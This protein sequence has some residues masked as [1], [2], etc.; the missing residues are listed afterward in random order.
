[1]RIVGDGPDY[2]RLRRLAGPNVE[3]LGAR[4]NEEIRK[5]YRGA[6]AFLLP[7]EED[8]GIAP[9]EALA[10]G[11]PVV[12]LDR[13]GGTREIMELT[14]QRERLVD[15]LIWRADWLRGAGPAREP[16]LSAFSVKRAT[17]AYSDALE[18]S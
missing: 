5:L 10:C 9:V 14:G 4:S 7:G 12:A 13:P 2:D 16:D 18:F 6:K 15:E 8:F 1:M 11:C 3:M 17:E